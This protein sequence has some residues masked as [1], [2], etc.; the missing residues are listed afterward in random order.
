VSEG[1]GW[2]TVITGKSRRPKTVSTRK[3]NYFHHSSYPLT[4]FLLNS[5]Q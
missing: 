5:P 1:I 2:D 3:K 4:F